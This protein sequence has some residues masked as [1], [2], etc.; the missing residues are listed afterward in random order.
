[1]ALGSLKCTSH[2]ISIRTQRNHQV[3]LDL[4]L[5]P[6]SL[7]L[8]QLKPNPEIE[9]NFYIINPYTFLRVEHQKLTSPKQNQLLP[10]ENRTENR[11]ILVALI[12]R[13]QKLCTKPLVLEEYTGF[14]VIIVYANLFVGVSDIDV[15]SEI[16]VER[17][18]VGG[19]VELC[20]R[21]VSDVKVDSVGAKDEPEDE[22]RNAYNDNNCA[23]KFEKE[24]NK[25]ATAAAIAAARAVVGSS[26]WQD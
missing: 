15:E 20:K 17:V 13:C 26:G 24:A 11:R 23:N 1:M 16:V 25:A 7:N 5:N 12:K 9:P 21:S 18:G 2:R 14:D 8:T 3:A 4:R 6:P 10:F 19:E 22:G